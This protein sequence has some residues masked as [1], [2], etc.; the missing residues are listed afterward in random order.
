MATNRADRAI[1]ALVGSR[2]HGVRW[3]V[4]G[5][6]AKSGTALHLRRAARTFSEPRPKSSEGYFTR[7]QVRAYS[8]QD[9]GEVC[10]L[11][12]RAHKVHISTVLPAAFPLRVDLVGRVVV[13]RNGQTITL[14][15]RK[16]LAI[17]LALVLDEEPH[18]N[19]Q[20][21]AALLWSDGAKD[22]RGSLRG[23][24][25]QLQIRLVEAVGFDHIKVDF[26][27]ISCDRSHLSS[28]VWD[29][30][31]A[32]ERGEVHPLLLSHE[33][34]AS[35]IA[36]DLDDLD[37]EFSHFLRTVCAKVHSR[38]IAALEARLP[39]NEEAPVTPEI[40][41]IALA[42]RRLS[43]QHERSVRCLM[44]ARVDTGDTGSALNI[45]NEFFNF[46]DQELDV[47]P[48]EATQLL[49]ARIKLGQI[50][51]RLHVDSALLNLRAPAG[52]L[53]L[54]DVE[55]RPSI[56][57]LPFQ[58]TSAEV[59]PYLAIGIVDSVIHAL[60]SL[61]ELLVISR[62]STSDYVVTSADLRAVGR[63]LGARYVLRG[64][65]QR[66]GDRLR[67]STELAVAETG[68]VVRAQ[69]LDG[70]I[71]GLFDLQDE[72][73]VEVARS[74]VPHIRDRELRMTQKHP[75][76]LTAYQLMLLGVDQMSR[77]E[78]AQFALA[79]QN[80]Q[81]AVDRSPD[82]ALAHAQIAMWHL[83]RVGQSW[84]SEPSRD[85]Q[86]SRENAQI[87]MR[88][89]PVDPSALAIYGYVQA[90]LDRDPESALKCID[91]AIEL[92]PNL[93]CAWTFRSATL[94]FAN[95]ALHRAIVDAKHA[96]KLA[97]RDV[98]ASLALLIIGQ[99]EYQNGNFSDAEFW[100]SRALAESPRN[101]PTYRIYIASLVAIG[102]MDEARVAALELRRVAPH[103]N[104]QNW[105]RSTPLPEKFRHSVA[106]A[107]TMSGLE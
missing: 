105:V 60:S 93:P 79:R 44:R 30:V 71:A 80:L 87:A 76:D 9:F 57:V 78:Y 23:A 72:I 49:V 65:V 98:F 10:A 74:L 61:K 12:K 1:A 6:A 36:P 17:L 20:R 50:T 34:L 28:D 29:V 51:P 41:A 22:P 101:I 85:A 89:D 16:E 95:V 33:Q 13:S 100:A 97:P 69:R 4:G 26:L 35:A 52:A 56:A 64:S 84:S 73:A 46:L 75:Q 59:Q 58:A 70:T 104:V 102:R 53:D 11:A 15:N 3:M 106:L 40:E 19:R 103:F 42:L 27:N 14:P 32:A 67:I 38:L 43:P 2:R 54:S 25:S 94:S 86:G 39:D 66:A 31:A 83:R 99:C 24:L 107:L 88:C 21:L 48:N 90:Y 5:D 68:E 18:L 45:Y 82:Y 7:R 47:E 96:I 92:C 62:A 8:L 63:A 37:E 55:T 81:R 91:S 77:L